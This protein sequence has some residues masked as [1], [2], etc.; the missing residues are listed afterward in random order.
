MDLPP[1]PELESDQSSIISTSD[2]LVHSDSDQSDD[3]R[4]N[5]KFRLPE[6]DKTKSPSSLMNDIPSLH[7]TESTRPPTPP[8]KDVIDSVIPQT[9][10]DMSSDL[11]NYLRNRGVSRTNSIYTLSRV[12]FTNQIQQ[13]TSI[14][15]PDASSLS[16]SIS[17]IPTSTGAGRALA[18]A[19]MQIKQWMSKASE[20]LSGLDAEDDVDWAAAAGREGLEEVDAAIT[21]FESLITV[22]IVAIEE[23]Q[24]RS[25]IASLSAQDQ[26]KLME[27][28]EEVVAKW[29]QIKSTLNTVKKN[30]EIAMEWEELWNSVLGEIGQELDGLSKLI[31]EMEERRHRSAMA[32]EGVGDGPEHIEIGELETI[33]EEAPRQNVK[34]V[35]NNRFSFT[36]AFGVNSPLLSPTSEA[37][38]EDSNLLK[39]FARMQPLRASLDFLP[40]RLAGFENR[41]LAAFPSAC[42]ELDTRRVQLENQW[43]QLE[44]EAE[45]LR[46]ELGE[47]RWVHLF[48][49]AASKAL[50]MWQSLNRSIIKLRR[51]FE[52][53][54]ESD[55]INMKLRSYEEKKPHYPPAIERVLAIIEKGIKDRL[56][57]NGEILRLQVDIRQKLA[58][59]NTEIKSMDAFLEDA[60]AGNSQQLRDSISSILSTERSFATSA[61]DTPGSSPASS[62]VM[63]RKSSDQGAAN[64]LNRAKSRQSSFASSSRGTSTP[65][66]RRLSSLPTPSNAG[67]AQSRI[68]R[69]SVLEIRNRSTPSPAPRMSSSTPT[70]GMSRRISAETQSTSRP[71]WNGSTNMNDTPLGHNFKPLSATLP[72]PYKKTLTPPS[73]PPRTLRSVSSHSAIPRPSPLSRNSAMSPP[74]GKIVRPASTTP[75]AQAAATALNNA[76]KRAGSSAPSPAT[77]ARPP[78]SALRSR[79]SMG[80]FTGGSSVTSVGRR[81]S[82]LLTPGPVEEEDDEPDASP[83]PKLKSIRPASALSGRRSSSMLPQ[84]KSRAVSGTAALATGRLSRQGSS[85]PETEEKPR[86]KH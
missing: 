6:L 61:F 54:A 11:E 28:M 34:A 56:T 12:S 17:A 84:L 38:Q 9:P 5:H 40:M 22:Y 77:P 75:A 67:S 57:V 76:A 79:S 72:S 18:E 1:P 73:Q 55:Y 20:V 42:G 63:S 53:G 45:A 74:P 43:Q 2:R 7:S 50:S 14:K 66:S 49:N 82:A 86:W 26:G 25:D 27:Q 32:N 68:S 33:V 29:S 8:P 51:A 65:S 48:R 64:P 52:D 41:A 39:L 46:R 59:L 78:G 31:F 60:F 19:A 3:L 35:A 81:S 36:P 24:A 70:P 4:E 10:G 44:S 30:V 23:L 58:D 85:R 21:L 71:R 83:T 80:N 47:D 62:I 13:L 15:L 16:T 69:P 37:K